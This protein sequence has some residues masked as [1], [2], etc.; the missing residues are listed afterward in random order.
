MKG[1]FVRLN[2]HLTNGGHFSNSVVT[3][4][5]EPGDTGSWCGALPTPQID[6]KGILTVTLDQRAI[7]ADFNVATREDYERCMPRDLCFYDADSKRCEACASATAEKRQVNCIRQGD[8]LPADIT[9]MST[10]DGTGKNPLDVVCQDWATY[11]SGT[12]SDTVGDLSLVDCPKTGC[13]GFAFTLPA[14]FVD[15]KRYNDKGA[16]A[17]RCFQRSE[18]INDALVSRPAAPTRSARRRTRPCRPTSATTALRGRRPPPRRRRAAQAG[19]RQRPTP[20]SASPRRRPTPAPAARC[21][22]RP[23]LAMPPPRRC[24]AASS[25]RRQPRRRH[26]HRV[27]ILRVPGA[28]T[29]LPIGPRL[30]EPG[31][32][33]G[34]HATRKR[35]LRVESQKRRFRLSGTPWR[36]AAP[37]GMLLLVCGCGSGFGAN[38]SIMT[39]SGPVRG[40]HAGTV[41]E[42][43]GIPYA[44]APVGA[45]RW[46]PPQPHGPWQGVLEAFDFGS[47][48]TQPGSSPD[49]TAG[50]EDC[51][52]LNVYRPHRRPGTIR[53]AIS[54]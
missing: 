50:S 41:D 7:A 21:R 17:S 38:D 27:T 9:S 5:C 36:R 48:C 46:L 40:M 31:R 11:A 52:F 35:T 26:R 10:P 3:D 39:E 8:F 6:D 2:P 13:L 15:N 16:D 23:R 20:A 19:H 42:Y 28:I 37:I 29:L 44:A 22:R 32:R 14:G 34:I 51:L 24:P 12:A 49:T 53:L 54:P 45:L 18:W 25:R 4:I 47:E 1:N 30:R 33:E 43:L